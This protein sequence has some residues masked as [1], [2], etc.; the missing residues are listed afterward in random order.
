MSEKQSSINILMIS[1]LPLWSM[2]EGKGAATFYKT[3]EGHV[4]RGAKVS[5]LLGDKSVT[6]LPRE[7]AVRTLEA[8]WLKFLI[9]I[10]HISVIAQMIWTF[11]FTIWAVTTGLYL[12]TKERF[13]CIYGYEITGVP[14]AWL[15]G[16]LNHVVAIARFQGTV[17]FPYLESWHHRIF[18]WD[19]LLAMVLPVD[20]IIMANDGTEGDKVLKYLGVPESRVRF[21]MNGINIGNATGNNL[22]VESRILT[23]KANG[24][25]VIMCVSRLV[26]WKRLDRVLAAMPAILTLDSGV[27]LVIVGE[28]LARKDYEQLAE[29]LKIE[30]NVIFVGSIPQEMIPDYLLQADLFVSFYDLSNLG[31]PLLEAMK[32][33]KCIIT[34]DNGATS[35]VIKSN[36]NGIMIDPNQL[37]KIPT[38]IHALLNNP[39]ERARLGNSAKE[40]ANTHFRTWS[41]RIDLEFEV[42][43][44]AINIKQHR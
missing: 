5:L 23:H 39:D 29:E 19:H 32:L 20:L 6:G 21:W 43:L 26:A 16:E 38:E 37:H 4:A 13:N 1:T 27:L 9:G 40:F 14:A 8:N 3:I 10:P 15:L 28:G 11:L 35:S 33:G 24:G 34:L 18:Y 36:I 44:E 25:K 42:I 2:G 30:S 31:N 17:L 22:A 41:Q 12:M 7:V